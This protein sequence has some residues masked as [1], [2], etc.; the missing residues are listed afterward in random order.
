M[1]ACF[2]HLLPVPSHSAWPGRSR[3]KACLKEEHARYSGQE[4]F[5]SVRNIREIV[6]TGGPV[7]GFLLKKRILSAWGF[8]RT[9]DSILSVLHSAMPRKFEL[10]ELGHDRFFWPGGLSPDSYRTC[11]VSPEGK[12]RRSSEEIPE[13]E[14]ANVMYEVLVGFHSCEPD[15]LYRETVRLFGF[16]A[17]T[18]KARKYPDSGFRALKRSGRIDGSPAFDGYGR[19]EGSGIRIRLSPFQRINSGAMKQGW[20]NLVSR[21]SRRAS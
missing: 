6:R 16:P 21:A 17:V 8:T 5:F 7:C 9:G 12:N 18:A 10:K 2:P 1:N 19:G 3:Q 11:R 4:S 15:T 13:E 20:K 14:L